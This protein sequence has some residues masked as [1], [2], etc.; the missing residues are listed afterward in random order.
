LCLVSLFC[1]LFVISQTDKHSKV[2][3]SSKI[4]ARKATRPKEVENDASAMAPNL[5]SASCDLDR[6]PPHPQRW[7]FQRWPF[8]AVVP[9]ITCFIW[10]KISSFVF[11]ISCLQDERTNG[12]V[13]NIMP[14]R[15]S[16]AW[17]SHKNTQTLHTPR[18]ACNAVRRI[19][20]SSSSSSSSNKVHPSISRV[21]AVNVT[22]RNSEC[23]VLRR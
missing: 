15:E 7:P 5:S 22:E 17:R 16:L 6:E 8:H 3:T 2:L 23:T 19:F 10:N 12:Q 14:P 11:R 1:R 20:S 9:G 13:E 4:P 21:S 18:Y